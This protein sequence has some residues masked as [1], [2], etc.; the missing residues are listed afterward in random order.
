MLATGDQGLHGI[1]LVAAANHSTWLLWS[2]KSFIH[3]SSRSKPSCLVVAG[4][5]TDCRLPSLFLLLH[6]I[7]T[8]L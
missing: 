5:I 3:K 7:S 2:S 6:L 1:A 8:S 4:L